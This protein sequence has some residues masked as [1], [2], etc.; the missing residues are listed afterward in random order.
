MIH[1]DKSEKSNKIILEYKKIIS[2]LS[3]NI[4]RLEDWGRRQL[5]YQIKK[6]SKAHY[7]L[8]NIE[9]P[10]K[11]IN[12]IENNLKLNDSIIRYIIIGVNKKISKMSPILKEKLE[13]QDKKENIVIKKINV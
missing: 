12:K 8:I 5:S 11:N 6:L 13:N 7:I 9:L 10:S 4:T 1:P 3:G 2:D